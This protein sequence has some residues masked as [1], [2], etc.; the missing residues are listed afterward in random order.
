MDTIVDDMDTQD[1]MLPSISS[2][3]DDREYVLTALDSL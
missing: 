3:C 1:L 2:D